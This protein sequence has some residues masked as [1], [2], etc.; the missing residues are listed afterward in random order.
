MDPSFLGRT[1][2]N[3]REEA[4][5]NRKE[6]KKEHFYLISSTLMSH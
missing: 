5:N 4:R 3:S 6:I 2:K 1:E